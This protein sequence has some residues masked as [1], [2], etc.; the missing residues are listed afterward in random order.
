M[1]L[2]LGLQVAEI[3]AIIA[4]AIDGGLIL[5]GAWRVWKARN[6]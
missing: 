1:A 3:G 5:F 4:I 2:V 6:E